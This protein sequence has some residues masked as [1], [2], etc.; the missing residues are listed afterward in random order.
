MAEVINLNRARKARAKAERTAQAD[1]NRRKF[2]RTKAEKAADTQAAARQ[3]AAL[4]GAK[5]ED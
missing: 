3:D 5:R 1:A 2:G 4:H